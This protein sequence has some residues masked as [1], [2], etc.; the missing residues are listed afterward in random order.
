MGWCSA[1][2]AARS[3]TVQSGTL[4]TTSTSGLLQL[5][6]QTSSLT[7]IATR[8]HADFR[9]ILMRIT[10]RG[11]T[12]KSPPGNGSHACP[13]QEAPSSVQFI[14]FVRQT[15]NEFITLRRGSAFLGNNDLMAAAAKVGHHSVFALLYL[16]NEHGG[17]RHSSASA[18]ARLSGY[19]TAQHLMRLA[20]KFNHPIVVFTTSQTSLQNAGITEPL[21]AH[22]FSNHVLSQ[23]K[24]KTPIILA[25]LSR[26]TSGDIFCTWIADKVLALEQTR[27]A[28]TIH[29]QDNS[30]PIQVGA[31]HLLRHGVIDQTVSVSTDGL[32]DLRVALPDSKLLNAA[33]SQLLGT[34]SHA[35]P[36][37]LMMQR[38]E[39]TN[40]ISKVLSNILGLAERITMLSSNG[41]IA[42]SRRPH[43]IDPERRITS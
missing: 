29:P 13:A 33:L 31:A 24:L 21:Q 39:R 26:R 34:V 8:Q 9:S 2:E 17:Y 35:S 28:M 16:R 12:M 11:L 38:K 42:I 1:G 36:Q 4:S 6:P 41:S 10:C 32:H 15:C 7:K 19:R 5:R 23:S 30:L 3:Y 43:F 27:F 20:Q 14:E 25:V 40:R 18:N 22:G 37:E